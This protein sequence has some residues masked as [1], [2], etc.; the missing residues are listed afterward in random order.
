MDMKIA[1]IA[2]ASSALLTR[3]SADF[4]EAPGLHAEDWSA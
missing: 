4:G 3:N 2:L 1:A